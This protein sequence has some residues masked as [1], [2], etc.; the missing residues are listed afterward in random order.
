VKSVSSTVEV[1]DTRRVISEVSGIPAEKLDSASRIGDD[2][3]LDS[4]GRVELLS[5]IEA[6]LG[7]YI[8]EQELASE[9]TVADL[10]QLVL[11]SGIAP[12]TNFRQWPLTIPCRFIRRGAHSCCL[13]P[14]LRALAHPVVRGRENLESLTGPVL[15]AA[16][17]NSHLDSL[18]VFYALPARFRSRLAVAAADDYFFQNSVLAWMTCLFMNGFPFAREGNIRTSLEYCGRLLDQG[19]SILIYPEGTRSPTGEMA[20]FKPGV[21]LLSVELGVSILPVR[22]LGLERILPKGRTIPRRGGNVQVHIGKPLYF[23]T[24][25]SHLEATRAIEK[26]VKSM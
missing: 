8:D 4:L 17:H 3:A 22:L 26:T 12:S 10:E 20:P 23:P 1:S 13:F 14:I 5:A 6:E 7:V 25:T 2:L 15:I 21:G 11:H 18:T 16:N 9:A 24:G 19:W